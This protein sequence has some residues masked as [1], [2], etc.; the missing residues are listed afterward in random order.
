M[1]KYH[2]KNLREHTTLIERER[3]S[4]SHE[5]VPHEAQST[6]SRSTV[7]TQKATATR[8]AFEKP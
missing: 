5:A 8:A 1:Q 3:S 6:G 4:E 7:C 2:A